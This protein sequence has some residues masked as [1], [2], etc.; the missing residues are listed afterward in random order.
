[1]MS[2]A[3]KADNHVINAVQLLQHKELSVNTATTAKVTLAAAFLPVRPPLD[4]QL[5][6]S[7]LQCGQ[8]DAKLLGCVVDRLAAVQCSQLRQAQLFT[9]L[10]GVQVKGK[11][12]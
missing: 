10:R 11:E 3:L 6:A 2:H 12:S 7:P 8:S 9:R 1:M 5:S 4:S